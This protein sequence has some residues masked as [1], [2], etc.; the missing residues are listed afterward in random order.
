MIQELWS[1]KYL[2]FFGSKLIEIL[3]ILD[4]KLRGLEARNKI[5]SAMKQAGA[6]NK[7]IDQDYF[8]EL[9]EDIETKVEFILKQE[10]N[11]KKTNDNIEK[12]NSFTKALDSA[13]FKDVPELTKKLREISIQHSE[14]KATTNAQKLEV[15]EFLAEYYE[16]IQLI[17]DTLIGLDQILKSFDPKNKTDD[18][19]TEN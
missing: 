2:F 1:H 11:I 10:N 6:I 14:L 5:A 9:N 18:N 7:L 15:T 17:G 19:Q 3:S 12:L 13:V 16:K 8:N 4:S